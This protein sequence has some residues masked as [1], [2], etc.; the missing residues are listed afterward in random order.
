MKLLLLISLFFGSIVTWSA[1]ASGSVIKKLCIKSE[2]NLVGASIVQSISVVSRFGFFLQAFSVAWILDQ[3]MFVG[4]RMLIVYTYISTMIIAIALVQIFFFQ[5]LN[6]LVGFF[7][8]D[9]LSNILLLHASDSKIDLAQKTNIVYVVGYFFLYLGAVFPL[10]VQLL[11]PDFSARGVAIA[12]IVNG[13]STILLVAYADVKM[14]LEIHRTKE[15]LIPDRL[16]VARYCAIIALS[17]ALIPFW[18]L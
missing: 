10:L 11:F 1:E 15:S 17:I 12:S 13:F 18:F 8:L 14:S 4:N 6:F 3:N 2:T 7:R 16:F 9:V 5:T